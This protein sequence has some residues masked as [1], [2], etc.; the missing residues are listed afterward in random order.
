LT[1][2][3]RSPGTSHRSPRS[4]HDALP[5]CRFVCTCCASGHCHTPSGVRMQVQLG[6][7]RRRVNT[8]FAKLCPRVPCLCISSC[9][10]QHSPK[11]R[12]EEHT[13][14]L[15]SRFELVCRLLLDKKT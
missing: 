15:Q 9:R 7:K 3:S 12:S 2:S 10:L 14:E 13:S 6:T 4:L 5:I 1:L 8:A 11:W